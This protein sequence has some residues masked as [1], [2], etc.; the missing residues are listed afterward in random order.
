MNSLL[1]VPTYIDAKLPKKLQHFPKIPQNCKKNCDFYVVSLTGKAKKAEF[2]LST[3]L[4]MNW[5][6]LIVIMA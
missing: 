3:S 2:A 6:D 1:C 4:R 5:L